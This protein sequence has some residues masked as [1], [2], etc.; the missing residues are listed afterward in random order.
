MPKLHDFAPTN[1]DPV[2][3]QQ[4]TSSQVAIYCLVGILTFEGFSM[5]G[6]PERFGLLF[7]LWDPRFG[8][9]V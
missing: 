9:T 6:I 2:H 3:A 8:V 1:R 4:S 7:P 5:L